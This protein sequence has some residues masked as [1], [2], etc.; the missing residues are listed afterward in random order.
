MNERCDRS[1]APV[2]ARVRIVGRMLAVA[3]AALVSA[4]CG[5]S[6]GGGSST[7]APPVARVRVPA[8]ASPGVAIS[9]DAFASSGTIER[10]VLDFDD[11][12][13]L[14]NPSRGFALHRFA[15][16][17]EYTVRATL[18]GAGATSTAE[19]TVHVVAEAGPTTR[20]DLPA[21]KERPS[22]G[23]IPWPSDLFRDATGHVAIDGVNVAN[24]IAKTVL[25][26]GLRQL[27]GFG[28]TTAAYV[29]LDADLDPASLPASAAAT[30][31]YGSPIVLMDVDPVS[32][33][34]RT[35]YPVLAS[36][37]ALDRRLSVLPE[38][39][40]PLRPKTRYALIVRTDLWGTRGGAPAGSLR[41]PDTLA[42][43]VAGATPTTPYGAEARAQAELLAAALASEP[44]F[45]GGD[46]SGVAAATVFTTQHIE[47]DLLAIRNALERGDSGVP[48]PSPRFDP[49]WIFGDGGRAS[50]DALVGEQPDSA[51]GLRP[52]AH[53]QVATIVTK[54]WFRSPIYLSP[55]PHFLD[56]YGGTFVVENGQPVVQRVIDL[57]FSLALP[58]TAPP[59]NGYPVVIAQHGLGGE[60]SSEL[61]VIANTLCA[62]GFAIAAIDAVQH[63]DRYDLSSFSPAL[64]QVLDPILK[65]I[66]F[67]L[68]EAAKD[69]APN[70]S[71]STLEGPDGWADPNGDGATIGLV[72]ALINLAGFRDN[73]RQN[74]VDHMSLARMLRRFDGEIPGVGRV[75]FDP[76]QLYYSGTSLGGILGANFV[77]YEPT[78]RAAN[79]HNAGGGLG[80]NLLV[81]SPGIGGL[82]GPLLGVAFGIGDDGFADPASPLVNLAQTV[83]DGGD[84]LNVAR[85]AIR[86]PLTYASGPAA[87]R[88]VLLLEAMW[89]YLVPNVANE[90]L[91]RTF[92][93]S[94]LEPSYRPVEGVASGGTRIEGNVN[95][96]TGALAQYSPAEHGTL[97]AYSPGGVYYEI[98]FPFPTGER[99]R[100]LEHDFGVRQPV[101]AAITQIRDFFLSVRD[102][103]PGT[104]E[105]KDGY[106][107]THDY[108]DD[109]V[110]DDDETA[111]GTNLSDP[112][113]HP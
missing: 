76:E 72:D 18:S 48:D 11:G 40:V 16:P 68:P 89:D 4:R 64:R 67:D 28:T 22:W 99:F 101:E 42:A 62:E 24:G 50:L 58:R 65:S 82:F 17:G 49:Q 1:A 46:L 83:I 45:A 9:V 103:G 80:V 2:R 41:P 96:K 66:G 71:Q 106:A 10:L 88:S 33:A 86:E 97:Y 59:P 63:G 39:G 92:G 25:E 54:A 55:D 52:K 108:D 93:L 37:D 95:G 87:P 26:A 36:F 35:R 27:D 77:S 113:S 12:T 100:A 5:D 34:Y 112:T 98:G 109:G 15:S 107:P 61:L 90:A 105:M 20:F 75:R 91:A 56:P 111:A 43:L 6:G 32:P 69:E 79:L 104:V 3:A 13:R 44:D 57:P 23:E 81:N 110:L 21:D 19:A 7:G 53:Q 31:A 8:Y 78:V 60:R 102:G 70:Y 30:V 14:V 94:L 29:W 73:F 85:H 38:P 74:V 84:P 47:D 51:P